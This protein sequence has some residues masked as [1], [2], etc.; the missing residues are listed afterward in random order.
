MFV[1]RRTAQF[2]LNPFTFQET[3]RMLE[4]FNKEEQALLYSATGGIPEYLSHVNNQLSVK[5]NLIE[6]FFSDNGVL[7]EEPSNLLKQELREPSTY[8]DIISA[9]AKGA[10]RLN[11][12]ST[13]TRLE[14]NKCSKYITSLLALGIIKKEQPVTESNSKK[15][16]YLLNDQMFR[17]AVT[18]SKK[19]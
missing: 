11:E 12:I 18:A 5:D 19:I 3:R 2:K 9:V 1:G 10:S 7:Y 8:N 6:L 17:F 14:S 16:I 4:V 13:K 15:T